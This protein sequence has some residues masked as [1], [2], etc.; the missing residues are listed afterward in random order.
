MSGA[1]APVAL[2]REAGP[3]SH[4]GDVTDPADPADS[5]PPGLVQ[6]YLA[7]ARR[8][9][10]VLA[11]L[12]ERLSA[13]PG[14]MEAVD[15]LRRESHK[16]RGSAG[17]FGFPAATDAAGQLEDAA[18]M[19]LAGA[20]PADAGARAL[21][22]VT[23]VRR[24]LGLDLPGEAAAPAPAHVPAAVPGVPEI[25]VVEDDAALAELLSYGLESRGY[26]FVLHRNG[27]EALEH[28]AA[29]DVRGTRPLVL[30]DVDLPGLDGYAVFEQLQQRRAG[31]YR[32]VFLTV[33]G[34][35]EEQLRGLE[36]GAIDYLV[37]P[38]LLRVALE[39]IRRW[40]GR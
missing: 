37:K 32:V 30:L 20:V 4:L 25:V 19:W 28:L 34:A 3:R 27:R 2:W 29:L 1:A 7:G 33:H 22:C 16:V 15:Q 24:A 11:G 23:S 12:A 39:K 31:T 5:L 17:S 9:L 14:D 35:E 6:E 8:Q 38:V 26:R 18:K 36:S 21:E 13:T 40:V 10:D